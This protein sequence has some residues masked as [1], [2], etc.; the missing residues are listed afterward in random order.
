MIIVDAPGMN[1]HRYDDLMYGKPGQ[2]VNETLLKFGYSLEDVYLAAP[3]LC[4][5]GRKS[6]GIG[7][8]PPDAMSLYSCRNRLLAEIEDCNPT[9]IM[10]MGAISTRVVTGLKD[11]ITEL[12]GSLKYIEDL[13]RWVLPTFSPNYILHAASYYDLFSNDVQRAI[14]IGEGE[15]ELP[16]EE[17][18]AK[19]TWI[20][21]QDV[22]L[23]L[24]CIREIHSGAYGFELAMDIETSGFDYQRDILLCIAIAN[25]EEAFVFQFKV[26]M[27][28]EVENAFKDLLTDPDFTW[29]FHN[30]SFDLQ[31]IS[32]TFETPVPQ[33]HAT[34]TMCYALGVTEQNSGVGLKYL[35]RKYFNAPYYE[36]IVKQYVKRSYADVPP[37]ILA[38]YA[39]LDVIYTAKLFPILV[40]ETTQQGTR[41]LVEEILVPGQLLFAEMEATGVAID[42]DFVRDLRDEWLPKIRQMEEDIVAFAHAQG[43]QGPFKPNS[44]KDKA[45]LFFDIMKYETPPSQKVNEA[46]RD[47]KEPPRHTGKEFYELYPDEPVTKLFQRYAL[48][49]KMMRTYVDGIVDDVS[50]A[51]RRVHPQFRIGGTV[52]GRLTITNPPLQTIP[53]DTTSDQDFASVK[54][55]FIAKARPEEGDLPGD[56]FTFIAADYKQL[57]LRV[58]WH[59]SE[60]PAMGAAIMSGDFHAEAAASILGKP[61]SEVTK[62]ERHNTKYVSFGIMYGRSPYALWKGQLGAAGLTLRQ[63]ELYHDGWLD[64]FPKYKEWRLE[65]QETAL[66]TGEL[67]SFFQR[68]RHWGLLTPEV[69]K[70][71]KNQAL[72]FPVQSMAS[73]INLKSAIR[74]NQILRQRGYGRPL[75]LVHDSIESEVRTEHLQEALDIIYKEMVTM[76]FESCATFDVDIEVGTTWGNAEKYTRHPESGLWMP[77]K[78][79]D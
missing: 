52:T 10:T 42:L 77:S 50:R 20:Q 19:Y 7:N 66:R 27:N 2:L 58:A 60:D 34:D 12:Q 36:D 49:T 70:E 69:V 25:D 26:F 43:W 67:R 24:E 38:K 73:D 14:L 32:W 5:P 37:N 28:P 59:L 22:R 13:N 63:C 17:L 79:K 3:V 23:A 16:R 11:S 8:N 1:D 39:A 75:F 64:Q 6:K 41:S 74:I 31:F 61:L 72:N 71:L 62:E 55:L 78:K 51:D 54:N 40:E 18:H 9:L 56:H 65:Q 35:S 4:Y 30:A 21:D 45:T 47:G 29:I 33:I 68:R 76:P 46:K 57:E 15:E 53:R 48:A 44:V